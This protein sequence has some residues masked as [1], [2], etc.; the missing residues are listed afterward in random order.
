M[1]RLLEEHSLAAAD[2]QGTGRDGR[3]TAQ[4]VARHAGNRTVDGDAARG[5]AARGGAARG[6]AAHGDA[7][8]AQRRSPASG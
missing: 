8:A 6:D 1:R 4:D 5:G 7:S 2:I 3:I